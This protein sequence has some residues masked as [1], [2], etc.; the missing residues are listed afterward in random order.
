[1]YHTPPQNMLTK[2]INYLFIYLFKKKICL[3]YM[4]TTYPDFRKRLVENLLV[5]LDGHVRKWKFDF[6]EMA[7]PFVFKKGFFV[8]IILGKYLPFLFFIFLEYFLFYIWVQSKIIVLR[9]DFFVFY[10]LFFLF[11]E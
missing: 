10:F 6:R 5:Y 4:S 3:S 11:W 7:R 9:G 8:V 2:G 1:V